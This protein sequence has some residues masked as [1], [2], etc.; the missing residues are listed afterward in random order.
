MKADG[1]VLSGRL[2]GGEDKQKMEITE[3][4]REGGKRPGVWYCSRPQSP[5]RPPTG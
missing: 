4:E 3:G 1:T 2:P 5:L